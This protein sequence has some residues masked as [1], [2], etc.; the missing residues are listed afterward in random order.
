MKKTP[1]KKASKLGALKPLKA[2]AA[3]KIIPLRR[4]IGA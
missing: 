2:E 1:V 3:P 4:P